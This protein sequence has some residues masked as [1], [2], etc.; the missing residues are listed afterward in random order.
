MGHRTKGI[1]KVKEG[2]ANGEVM[3]FSI[4]ENGCTGKDMIKGAVNP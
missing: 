3:M 2:E 1:F 4:I